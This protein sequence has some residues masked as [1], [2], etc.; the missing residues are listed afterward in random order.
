MA[1]K[2]YTK[3]GDL[4]ETSL[5]GKAGV[6]RT[7]KD[8]LRVESYGAVDEANA[9]I[10]MARAK[11]DPALDQMLERVQHRLFALGADLS[12]INPDRVCRIGDEDVLMLEAWI[13]A[14][15]QSLPA[16]KEFI[17]PGG[18]ETA[19]ALHLARTVV[20]RAERRL[21]S[22]LA[23]EPSY[24]VHLK[25]LNRL[26]DFLFVAARRANQVSGVGDITAKF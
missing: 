21:V 24:R 16:L 2:I 25:F 20:R 8:S 10:G 19:S 14:L 3:T 12:N 1:M 13:D 17:L 7:R 26:S 15:D 23:E 18:S 9:S 6:K 11:A 22:F 5:W 4:G